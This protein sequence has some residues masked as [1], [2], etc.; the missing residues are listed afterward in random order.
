MT[1]NPTQP[2]LPTETKASD[3]GFNP[4]LNLSYQPT[5]ELNTYVTAAKGFRPGGANILIPPPTQVPYCAPGSPETFGPDSVWNYEIGEK[6][7]LL[8]N[9][10]SINGDFFYIK[11]DGIQQSV[12]LA[13]GYVYN[14]N[15]GD[16]RSYGPE[17]EVTAKL[18]ESWTIA[19]NGGITNAV[20]TNPTAAFANSL[21]G[22]NTQPYCASSTNC[23]VPILN[24][25]HQT[26]ALSVVY[27]T[28]LGDGYRLTA[29]ASD[30]YTGFATDE[31]FYFGVHLPPYAIAAARLS[32]AHDAW[33]AHL[34][35]DNL[36]N[37]TALMT[38]NNT[39]FQFN[40]AQLT[41]YTVNQ[42]RTVGVQLNYAF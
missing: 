22:T 25:P 5:P 36:T 42:P 9:R 33:S 10:V 29:R 38:A 21:I 37:K 14:T 30:T 35:A 6:A 24:V 28:E 31:A 16:G 20:I 27:S 32:I 8:G 1:P 34:F 11:W 17:L 39:Q 19:A 2:A 13:C 15:A 41:R 26:A 4:R 12:P 3:R 23:S 40:I 7:K 18:D